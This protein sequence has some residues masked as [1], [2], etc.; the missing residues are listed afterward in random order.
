MKTEISQFIQEFAHNYP[1][2]ESTQTCWKTPLFGVADAQDPLFSRL[3]DLISP[4][5]AI[6]QDIIP[7]AKSVI[8]YFLP[9]Q[10]YLGK[11]NHEGRFASREWAIAYEETNQLI[12]D[13]NQALH[14]YLGDRGYQSSLLP[15][16][17]IFDRKKLISDWSH[18][19]IAYIA[20]LGRF[21]LNNM[22]ITDMGCCGR[23]GSIATDLELQPTPLIEKERCLFKFNGSC[24]K[25]V[26]RCVNDALHCDR[27][28]RFK[29]HEICIQN[30]LRHPDLGK[31]EVCGKCVVTIP[32]SH[33]NPVK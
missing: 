13:I 33:K 23:I 9:F 21:G 17:H 30:D 16:T 12:V 4:S 18:R 24:Q 28:D 14:E 27:F 29:C 19:H 20:G 22:L 3:K 32:C 8:A 6:P 26:E 31:T 15:A 11:S 5:H 7:G 2:S 1:K 10:E 25:C